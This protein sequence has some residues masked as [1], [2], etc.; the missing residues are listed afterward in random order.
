MT[1]RKTAIENYFK[2]YTAM[3]A[4]NRSTVRLISVLLLLG[5]TLAFGDGMTITISNNTTKDLLVTVYE[6]NTNPVQRVVAS[7]LIN[8]FASIPLTIAADGSGQ[9]HLSWSATSGDRNM[10]TCG[11]RDRPH[12]NNSDTVHVYAN[13]ECT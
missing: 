5:S 10:R 11:H 7:A 13:S 4:C 3:R 8:G 9:G 1:K 6:L 2:T 12:V